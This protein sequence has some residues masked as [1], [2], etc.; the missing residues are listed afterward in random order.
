MIDFGTVRPG[1]T[2]YIPFHTFDS[3]DPSA[4][5]T[6][7]GL[8][9]TDIEV[10]KDGS[11]TQRASDAGYALL[12][13]DGIDF[14]TTTGIHGISIDLADNTT[15]EFY[16]SGHQYW[17][18]IASITVDAA[19]I[20]FLAATFRIG[21]PD[22]I[23]NSHIDTLSMQT[24]FTLPSGMGSGDNDAYNGWVAVIHDLASAVQV[25]SAFISDYVGSTR[26]VT[27]AA[28]PGFT[29]AAGDNIAL[30]PPAQVSSWNAVPLA[31]TN[32][33]PNAAADAA[34]GL[35]VSDLGGLDLDARLD[36][37]VSSRLA[38]TVAS[39]TLDVTATGAAGVDWAN[40]EGQGSTVNLSATTTNLVNTTTTNTDMRGTDNA[41]L[42]SVL[43]ALADAAAAGDPTASDTVVQYLKQIVN[44]LEG[45]AG[46][47]TFPAEA[48]PGNAV[49]LAEIVRAIHTD[50]T[51]LNGAAMRGTDSAALASVCTEARLAEL[52]AANLPTDVANIEADT[53]D[54]QGRIPAVGPVE[55][56]ADSG[57]TTTMVDAA[58]TEG[59]DYWN[60]AW[61]LFT[62]GTLNGVVRLVTDFVAASDTMTIS[63]AAP[64]AVSTH[65]Y[66]MIPAAHLEEVLTLTG[67]TVQTG[68]SFARLGAPAGASVSADIATVDTVVDGIQTDLDNGTDGLG[69]IKTTAD[70]IETDTQNIQSRLPAALVSG[71]MDADATSISGDATAADRLE[72]L[73]DGV[74][75]AAAEGTP[76]TTVI[77]TDLA[78]TTDDQYIG[79]LVTFLTGNAAGEQTDITDY[80]GST[81]TITVT[82][83]ANAP[84]AG[85]LMVIH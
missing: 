33:L 55:G 36:A 43:G 70:A 37:A 79:R 19:T 53:Q 73:M 67:H 22:A 42:A 63:P 31:T 74:L 49:S 38:P 40:V 10:Y 45:T 77:Q 9:T 61:I 39:R 4:S 52:D 84:T 17:V 80:T 41:A 54:I 20:N 32:P 26:T 82:A 72:A 48:A 13:T 83:L 1:T 58:R 14:D 30:F 8:A 23:L 18:V 68:D 28:A 2:L 51:G 6:I 60:G 59:D 85:D 7:T 78:E 57:S 21:Y 25:A 11:V 56:T 29:I 44:T 3:N 76:S 81:G 35:P 62:S 64:A 71:K 16:Q 5:V 12:D 69:A 34:G 27:L 75:T 65:T 15:A 46:I 50:V 66:R 47:P 24:S